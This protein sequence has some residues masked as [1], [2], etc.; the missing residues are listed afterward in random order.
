MVLARLR[1]WFLACN[2]CARVFRL[3]R[4]PG[5]RRFAINPPLAR[6]MVAW[7]KAVVRKSPQALIYLFRDEL[8]AGLPFRL[9][10]PMN[11]DDLTNGA[12]VEAAAFRLCENV[13]H[14]RRQ[15]GSLLLQSLNALNRRAE[16]ITVQAGTFPIGH[17]HLL[18]FASFPGARRG[19]PIPEVISVC[20][21]DPVPRFFECNPDQMIRSERRY[22]TIVL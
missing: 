11:A 1:G 17:F 16:P 14:V 7:P 9:I 5:Q 21:L 18:F 22:T 15:L 13:P 12:H 4:H 20:G 10:L 2:S 19:A 3:Q 8:L 6:T